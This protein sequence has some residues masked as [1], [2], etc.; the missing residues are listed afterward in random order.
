MPSPPHARAF[1]GLS[2][3]SSVANSRYFPN[4]LCVF[5]AHPLTLLFIFY[6]QRVAALRPTPRYALHWLPRQQG[7]NIS[8]RHASDALAAQ[9]RV[10][11]ALAADWTSLASLKYSMSFL[12]TAAH[13]V[14]TYYNNLP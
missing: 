13:S 10:Q 8:L 6:L 12:A 1:T 11:C 5:R 4:S 9:S 7:G 3:F 14:R 2:V